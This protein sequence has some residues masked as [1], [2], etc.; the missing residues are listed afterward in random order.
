MVPLPEVLI[1][2][3]LTSL[4]IEVTP[5]PNMAWIALLSATSGRAAGFAAVG[6]IALGLGIQGLLAALGLAAIITAWPAVYLALHLAGVGFLVWLAWESWRDAGDP[7]HHL[8]GGGETVSDGFG[9]GLVSNLLNPKAAVFFVSVLPGF[10]AAK[11]GVDVALVLSALYVAVATTVHGAIVLAA[12]GLRGWL[13]SPAF[14]ARMH[15]FQAIALLLV[16]IWLLS[17]G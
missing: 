9:R 3:L 13:A 14:S 6:G 8:P 16:A 7:V 4:V 17:R 15:R 11:D 1:P 5:G 2:F 12:G 10:L